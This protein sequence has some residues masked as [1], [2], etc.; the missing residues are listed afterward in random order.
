[1][2]PYTGSTREASQSKIRFIKVLSFTLQVMQTYLE[3]ITSSRL[4]MVSS[5]LR[6]TNPRKY[7]E[8]NKMKDG[9]RYA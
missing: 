1:M 5:H 2:L 8:G 7:I 9:S 3:N 6:S 4:Q